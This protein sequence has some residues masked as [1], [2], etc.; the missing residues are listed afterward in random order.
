M[1]LVSDG[2]LGETDECARKKTIKNAGHVS[3]NLYHRA[4]LLT[5]ARD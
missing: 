3:A 2:G 5:G 1:Q 4:V